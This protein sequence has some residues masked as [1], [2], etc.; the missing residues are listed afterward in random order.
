M[1]LLQFDEVGTLKNFQLLL[2]LVFAFWVGS[3]SG[4]TWK[5]GS[6]SGSFGFGWSRS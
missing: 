2:V 3:R 6:V 4:M 1:V 5:R